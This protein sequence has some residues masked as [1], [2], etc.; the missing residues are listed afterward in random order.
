MS[1][2]CGTCVVAVNGTHPRTLFG[3]DARGKITLITIGSTVPGRRRGVSLPAAAHILARLGVKNA[4]NLD[5]GGSST[6]VRHGHVVNNPSDGHPRKVSN[7]WIVT[8]ARR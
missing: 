5:G 8:I 3:W 4:V 7:A 2:D 6:F 1:H